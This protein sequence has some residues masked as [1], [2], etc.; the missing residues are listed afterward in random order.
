[1]LPIVPKTTGQGGSF[2]PPRKIMK[3]LYF[4]M[5]SE[6]LYYCIKVTLA[7]CTVRIHSSML[8]TKQEWF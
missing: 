4:E 8:E 7:G 3:M 1:M 5:L 2:P 6:G